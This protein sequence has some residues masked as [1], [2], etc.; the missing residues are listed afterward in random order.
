[1]SFYQRT[2]A[3]RGGTVTLSLDANLFGL[4]TEDRTLLG[5]LIDACD[6]YEGKRPSSQQVLSPEELNAAIEEV[7]AR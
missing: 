5:L 6:A 3:V 7:R 1:M 4:T 2:V